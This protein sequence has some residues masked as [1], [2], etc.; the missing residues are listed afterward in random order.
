MILLN[1]KKQKYEYLDDK[2]RDIM[3]KT[4]DFFE[5]KGKKKLKIDDHD[6]VWN[7]DFVEFLKKE[8]VF[9]TLMTPAGYGADDSSWNTFRNCAFNELVAF[10]G[11]C[12]WYTWQVSM[13][14]LGPI[15][16]SKNEEIKH[17]TAK[18]LQEGAVFAFGVSEKEHGADLY[19]SEVK[20]L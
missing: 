11:S 19:S 20:L 17:K 12:Y 18:M 3:L 6:C 7:Y 4:I 14:G 13:L 2:S 8:K 1:P 16:M 10:Y 15:W 5:N 9:A